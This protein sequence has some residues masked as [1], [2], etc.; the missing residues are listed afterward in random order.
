MVGVLS[1]RSELF[2]PVRVVTMKPAWKMRRV[3]ARPFP[4]LLCCVG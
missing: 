4:P 2:A 3:Q 1:K